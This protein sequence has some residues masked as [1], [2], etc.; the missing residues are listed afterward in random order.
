MKMYLYAARPSKG[1]RAL[2]RALGIK[3]IRTSNS[4]YKPKPTDII[5]N[6]GNTV[7]PVFY[8]ARVLN[9]PQAVDNATNKLAAYMIMEAAEVP[10]PQFTDDR[11]VAIEWTEK[12][13]L[14]LGRRLLRASGGRGIEQYRTTAELKAMPA[15]PLYT[16]YRKK[17][18]EYRVHIVDGQVIDIQQKRRATSDGR[19]KGENKIRNATGGWVFTREGVNAPA[20]IIE[21]ATKAVG[22]LGLDFGAADCGYSVGKDAATVYEVNTAP[23]LEATTLVRYRA[24]LKSFRG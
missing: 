14:V 9:T 3:K 12:G 2:S 15:C 6:W 18:D 7:I 23:G 19:W 21:A 5:V 8:P 16:L 24:G 4:R 22:C 13:Y 17:K 20:S 11:E 1:A 10:V